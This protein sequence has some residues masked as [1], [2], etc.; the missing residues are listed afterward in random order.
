MAPQELRA[1]VRRTPFAP[2]RLTLTEGSSYEIRHPDLCMVGHRSA[3]L[4]LGADPNDPDAL[5]ERSVT[6]DLLHIVKL[7]PLESA[8]SPS[9]N[10]P[11]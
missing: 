8:A 2:F 7:E 3:V 4:G 11:A 5:F 9:T 10:G 1:A 6:V